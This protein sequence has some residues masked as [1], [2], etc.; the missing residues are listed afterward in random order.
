MTATRARSAIG[1]AAGLA[2][3]LAGC[4]SSTEPAAEE[5][6]SSAPASET[7]TEASDDE[8]QAGTT[9]DA[10][11]DASADEGTDVAVPAAMDF[12][13]P[14]VSG[15][16]IDA[17][18][19]AGEPT[20][21]WFWAPWCTV[22]RGEAPSVT[23]VAEDLDGEVT[24]VG[25]A[26]LGETDAMVEFVDSTGVTGF[27]HV[28]DADGSIWTGFGVVSQPSF[29]FVDADGEMET[30]VGAMGLESLESTSRDL[31]DG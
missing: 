1:A 5:T 2:L 24:F 27:E 30:V 26:G 7:S 22:C 23:Q 13:A 6:E 15:G 14:T 8:S 3:L 25:V 17:A 31:V 20:V 11:D 21:F 9:E 16:E 29:V 28:V 18:A 19:L 10:A 4:A 12:T